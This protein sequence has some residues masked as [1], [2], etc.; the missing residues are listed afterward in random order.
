M[1]W[2]GDAL[3]NLLPEVHRTRDAERGSPLRQYLAV[4]AEQA[5]LLEEDTALLYDNAFVETAADWV[6]PYIGDLIGYRTIHGIAAALNRRAEIANTIA[7][8]RRKGTVVM[9]E[10]LA[11]DVTGWPA[12]AKEFFQILLTNQHMNHVRPFN[13]GSPDLRRW[14][15]LERLE[16][17]FD[18]VAHTV[19][20]GRIPIGEGRHN[21]RNVGL[22]LWRLRAYPVRTSMAG[23]HPADA[24][25]YF[26]SPLA[27]DAPLFNP[28]VAEADIVSLAGPLNVPEPI[29]RRRLGANLAQY[30]PRALRI[31]ADGVVLGLSDVRGCHLGDA[32]GG[33]WAHTPDNVVAIDPVLGRIN[34]PPNRPAPSDVRVLFHHGFSADIGGGAYERAATF[35]PELAPVRPV[36]NGDPLQP[37]ITQV[38]SGGA[39]EIRD[40][41]RYDG[42]LTVT[43]DAD[44]RLE[45]RGANGQRP[46]VS[47]TGDLV[48]TGG[49][50][51]EVSLNGLLVAGGRVVVPAAGNAVRRLRVSHCTLVPGRE[52]NMDGT[53][54]APGAPSLVIEAE[55]VLV[56]IEQSIVGPILAPPS[57]Q[58]HII[59]SIVD[60]TTPTNV[61]M[62]AP[63]GAA[64]G[65]TL[66]M[67]D[68]T[69]IGK[70]HVTAMILVSNSI[71][72]AALAPGDTWTAPVRSMRRQIGCIRFSYVPPR[73]S[74]PRRFRCQPAHAIARAVREARDAN[75]LIGPAEVAAITA[76]VRARIRPSWTDLRYGRPAYAQLL[77]ATPLDIRAGADDES[78]MG[79]FHKLYQPQR[80][81]NLRIRL[82]EF[83][84]VGLEAGAI[85]E[86]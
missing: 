11:R 79:A 16:G 41:L 19:D 6:L 32:G 5:R 46:F 38:Q 68:T 14:E 2:N 12:H 26:F 49:A 9:L 51:G 76:A 7:Y 86:T 30:Y 85:V 43:V 50:D 20:V 13:A 33:L 31:E 28:P 18:T 24:R 1:S 83:L 78:E 58:L 15:P 77:R 64:P 61:A 84:G 39:V 27:A 36:V 3:Y 4:L 55:N 17:A 72:D 45:L 71:I 82:E 59:D 54:A 56:E 22:F 57:T 23:A 48:I 10:Q 62:A 47:L 34:F 52:L 60:A 80:E 8:R 21:I 25:R 53:P 42:A 74:V 44:R 63:D 35:A 75:P 40:S 81:A 29:G 37:E 73:S 66:H 67:I 70:V 65:P 69:V